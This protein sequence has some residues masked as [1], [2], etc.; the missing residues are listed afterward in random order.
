[1]FPLLPQIAR[2]QSIQNSLNDSFWAKTMNISIHRW[3]MCNAL[4]IAYKEIYR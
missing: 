1:M 4:C 2:S 3:T